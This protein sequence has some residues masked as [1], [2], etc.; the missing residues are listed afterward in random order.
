MTVGRPRKTPPTYKLFWVQFSSDTLE[1]LDHYARQ[2][3]SQRG[4]RVTRQDALRA[5]V[6]VWGAKYRKQAEESRR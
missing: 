6:A 1:L 3:E 2:L 5:V 4:A